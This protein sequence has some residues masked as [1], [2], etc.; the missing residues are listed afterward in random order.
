MACFLMISLSLSLLL[1]E[2]SA[3][4]ATVANKDRAQVET[5]KLIRVMH[6]CCVLPSSANEKGPVS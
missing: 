6:P 2:A 4:A 3:I 1:D 5:L